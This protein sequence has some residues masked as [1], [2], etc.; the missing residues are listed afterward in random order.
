MAGNK[1][2]PK[3]DVRLR[4]IV[5]NVIF[6]LK[7]AMQTDKVLVLGYIGVTCI[8]RVINAVV[9]VVII[10]Q[11]INSIVNHAAPSVMLRYIIMAVIIITADIFLSNGAG[12]WKDTRLVRATKNIQRQLLE[13]SAKVDL[14]C[15]DNPAY[16]E[17]FIIAAS[18][19][20]QMI[21]QAVNSVASILGDSLSIIS[22]G[23]LIMS[24]NPVIAFFPVAGFIVNITTRFAIQKLEYEYDMEKKAVN[25]KADYSKRVFYQPE[26]AKEIKL[27]DIE[28]PLKNQFLEAIEEEKA[29]A[30]KYGTKIAGLS[31]VNWIFSFTVF[32]F[33]CVPVYLGYLAIVRKIIALGDVAALNSAADT[34]QWQLDQMNYALIDFQKVGQYAHRFKRFLDYKENLE[35]WEGDTKIPDNENG[36]E[37]KNISFRYDGADVCTLKNIS[38]SIK[39]GERIAIVGENGAGKTTF[40]KLLMRLYDVTDGEIKFGGNDIKR[41]STADYRSKI[42]AVFQEYQLYA[43]TLAENIKMNITDNSDDERLNKALSFSDF[44]K[45]LGNLKNGLYTEVT[46]EFSDEGTLFSGGESQKIAIARMFAGER[47]PSL[48]ILDEPSSALDPKAEY[49]LN[50]NISEKAGDCTVIFISHRLS[51]TRSADRIYL[52]EKGRITEQGSHNELMERNGKYAEMFALQAA[53]YQ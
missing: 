39:K 41:Y 8:S 33:F 30:K 3:E 9:H 15:Y 42:A 50:Q 36:L 21:S 20:D 12:L 5:G 53:N 43:A 29:I 38:M 52:F 46:K 34:I 11:L 48:A 37:I 51:T 45:K 22:C 26:Y 23:I 10:R 25:R 49:I 14:I 7:Y 2:K 18:Q 47:N 16:Y 32:R 31:L 44:G 35:V 6:V 13:K 24:I 28:L 27:T 19:A 1:E 4:T 40:V 17:D